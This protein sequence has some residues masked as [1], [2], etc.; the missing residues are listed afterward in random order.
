MKITK[1]MVEYWYGDLILPKEAVKD[2]VDIANG[3]YDVITL[4]TD[5]RLSW[6]GKE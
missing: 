1:E 3:D 5:I 2:I 6:R 4:K